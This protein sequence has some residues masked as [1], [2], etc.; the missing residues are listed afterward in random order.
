MAV[1]NISRNALLGQE[2]N[3]R[4]L[5]SKTKVLNIFWNIPESI[6]TRFDRQI[7]RELIKTGNSTENSNLP[8]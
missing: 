6:G 4:G 8:M 5:H 3:L 1:S 2:K 7:I